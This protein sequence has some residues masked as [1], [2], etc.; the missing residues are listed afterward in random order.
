MSRADYGWWVTQARQRLGYHSTPEYYQELCCGKESRR[1]LVIADDS[2][3]RQ[4]SSIVAGL[5][6]GLA[7]G[8][9]EFDDALGYITQTIRYYHDTGTVELMR[10][11]LLA[12]VLDQMGHHESAATINGFAASALARASFPEITAAVTHLKEVLGD[13]R[14]RSLSMAGAAM[15]TTEITDYAF[16]TIARVRSELAAKA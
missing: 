5:L 8:R 4:Q 13:E 10:S 14:Y 11:G 15:S 7:A 16:A 6:T 9:G 1:A 12:T 2:G 3:D